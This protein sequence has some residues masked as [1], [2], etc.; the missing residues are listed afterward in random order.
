M[1]LIS[2]ERIKIQN[3]NALSSAYTIGFPAIPAWLGFMHAL[4]RNL[5]NEGIDNLALISVGV[6]SHKFHLH[7]YKG[8]GDYVSS[9]IGTGNPLDKHGQRTPFIE[10][11]RCDLT[12]SL[13]IKFFFI[14]DQ[15]RMFSDNEILKINNVINR[16]KIAGGDIL[17]FKKITSHESIYYLES[18]RDD[19][20]ANII[21]TITRKLMPGY[22]LI[23]RRDLMQSE[24]QDG[25]SDALDAILNY[26]AIEHTCVKKEGIINW[27]TAKKESGWI[28]PIAVGFQGISEFGMADN[29][30]DLNVQHC[31]AE[32]VVTLG[33]FKMLHHFKDLNDLFWEYDYAKASFDAKLFLCV[34]TKSNN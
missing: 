16:M 2:L 27:R 34:Q 29:Q 17:D 6:I 8:S 33:E 10:S 19:E 21:P 14:D 30:R 22:A 28:V 9:I 12:V 31:F 1:N 13:L 25:K 11:P 5:K 4:E 7:T 3:A 18:Y 20:L 32:S 23:D 15:N 26:L 24:M